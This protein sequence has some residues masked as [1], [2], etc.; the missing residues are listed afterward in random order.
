MRCKVFQARSLAAGLHHVPHDIL[1]DA[2]APHLSCPG[3]GS[4][5]PSIPDPGC[6]RPLIER[7]F[8]PCWNGDGADMSAPADQV[9]H[10]P[11]PLAHLDFIQ[12][13]THQL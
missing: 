6:G 4:K 7:S 13:Q 11:V 5:D 10:C 3:D 8:H 9:H 12:F 2:L 1:R